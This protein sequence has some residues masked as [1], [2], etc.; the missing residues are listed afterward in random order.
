MNIVG[1]TDHVHGAFTTTYTN[2]GLGRLTSADDGTR[3][4]IWTLTQPGN[5]SHHAYNSDAGADSTYLDIGDYEW[6]GAAYNVAN[7]PLDRDVD[8]GNGTGTPDSES[9]PSSWPTSGAIAY[10]AAGNLKDDSWQYSFVYDAWNRLVAVGEG[11]LLDGPWAGTKYRYNGLGWRITAINDTDADGSFGD[12][13]TEHYA[14]TAG[15]QRCATYHDAS[16]DPYEIFIHHNVGLDGV[17][18]RMHRSRDSARQ[19]D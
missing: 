2:D 7:E 10:D 9:Y 11:G 5:W 15:W 18:S 1:Q 16:E 3:D 6:D 19:C 13:V 4:E 17:T 8:W 14:Y 12:E